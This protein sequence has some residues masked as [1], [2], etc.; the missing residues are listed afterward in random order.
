MSVYHKNIMSLW[1]SKFKNE[2]QAAMQSYLVINLIL[3]VIFIIACV[4]VY[5]LVLIPLIES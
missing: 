5:L 4:F 1:L 2:I 3:L